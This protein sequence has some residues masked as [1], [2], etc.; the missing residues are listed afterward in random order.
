MCSC[1][2]ASG[3]VVGI[4]MFEPTARRCPS[5]VSL[6]MRRVGAGPTYGKEYSRLHRGV[7]AGQ[8]QA[9]H[10]KLASPQHN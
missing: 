1:S 6:G 4:K 2:M 5:R 9:V 10:M 8:R 3:Q 7:D